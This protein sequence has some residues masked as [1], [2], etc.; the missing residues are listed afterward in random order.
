MGKKYTTQPVEVEISWDA[1][2]DPGT[3]SSAVI[4]YRKPDGTEGNWTA[5]YSGNDRKVYYITATAETY[6]MKGPWTFWP[7]VTLSDGKT[8]P[9]EP[10]FEEIYNEGE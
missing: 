5:V 10:I 4:K 9:G 8:I 1:A 3:V 6:T 7:V 2:D